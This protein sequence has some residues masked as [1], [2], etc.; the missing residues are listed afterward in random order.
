MGWDEDTPD[1]DQPAESDPPSA[2]SRGALGS[3][4]KSTGMVAGGMLGAPFGPLGISLGA[5][6]GYLTGELASRGASRVKGPISGKPLT[7]GDI[8]EVPQEDRPYAVAG[9]VLGGSPAFAALPF[10]AAKEAAQ[11]SIPAVRTIVGL[12]QRTPKSFLATEALGIAGSAGGGAA[13]EYLY[14]D[15][16]LARMGGEVIGGIAAPGRGVMPLA[17]GGLTLGKRAWQAISPEARRNEAAGIVQGLVQKHGEDP[18]AV[19]LALRDNPLPEIRG[20]AAQRSGSPGLRAMENTLASMNE[21]FGSAAR[22]YTEQALA[23]LRQNIEIMEMSGNPV[24]L[25]AASQER[26]RYFSMLFEGRLAKAEKDAVDTTA[27]MGTDVT[28]AQASTAMRGSLDRSLRMSRDQEREL[29][30]KVERNLPGRTDS[31]LAEYGSLKANMLPEETLPA[32]VEGRIKA[33]TKGHQPNT[34]ELIIFRSRMLELAREAADKNEWRDANAYGRMAEAALDELDGV[35]AAFGGVAYDR[36][37]TFS[38]SM[39]DAFTRTFTGTAM[40]TG[41]MGRDRIPPELLAARAFGSGKEGAALRFDQ[42]AEAAKFMPSLGKGGEAEANAMM[43][44]QEDFL[45][46]AATELVDP[47]TGM[48]DPRRLAQFRRSNAELIGRF[49]QTM[50]LFAD[51]QTAQETLANVKGSVQQAQRAIQ[52]DAAFVRIAGADNPQQAVSSIIGNFPKMRQLTRLA[53]DD[54]PQAVEGYRRALIGHAIDSSTNAVGAFSFQKFRETM[55]NRMGP[56]RPSLATFM[57][58]EGLLSPQDATRINQI[59]HEAEKRIAASMDPSRV[60][61]IVGEADVFTDFTL[62][63]LGANIGSHGAL[64]GSTGA[65]LVAAHAGSK[66]VKKMFD[67]VPAG[68]VKDLLIEAS[69]NDRLMQSLLTRPVTPGQKMRIGMQ[70]NAGLWN[71]GLNEPLAEQT[72]QT[73]PVEPPPASQANG[74]GAIQ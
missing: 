25:K 36:A 29:W 55:F 7:Y 70:I 51:A 53:R 14:P 27:K 1:P 33:Y 4:L 19:A 8:S 71:A 2:L 65:P 52:R 41:P 31:I 59:T 67:K 26:E 74:E 13:M 73:M 44:A 16:P 54:G 68:R 50:G 64:S 37:R 22:K 38:R 42:M 18:Q 34:G 23:M 48:V 46:A 21:D 11:Y 62:R 30:S 61:E 60:D 66:M 47:R 3:G 9:E 56:G 32:L 15:D 72:R 63:V 28:R 10:R 12:A 39:Q 40:D 20:T 45:K 57:R 5:A 6:A 35:F 58:Q 49:P 69:L 24:A 17:R 43:A